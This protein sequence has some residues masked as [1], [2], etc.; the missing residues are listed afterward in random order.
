MHVHTG[1]HARGRTF[2]SPAMISVVP[3]SVCSVKIARPRSVSPQIPPPHRRRPVDA[4]P[5]RS[6]RRMGKPTALR[7]VLSKMQSLGCATALHRKRGNDTHWPAQNPGQP[8][9]GMP[10]GPGPPQVMTHTARSVAKPRIAAPSHMRSESPP[11]TRPRSQR[12]HRDTSYV[13]LFQLRHSL[14]IYVR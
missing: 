10:D 2:Y 4:P 14:L 12:R 3:P 8:R 6:S 1:P 9:G 13:V 7:G 5:Q 11:R